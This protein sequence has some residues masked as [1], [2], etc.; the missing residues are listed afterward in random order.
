MK[1]KAKRWGNSLG[2]RLPKIYTEE[3]GI[4][5]DTELNLV[6][7]KGKLIITK[8]KKDTLEGM[9]ALVTQENIHAETSTGNVI[10][11]EIW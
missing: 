5:S 4:G 8:D 2:L 1:V 6:S 10:G 3:L 7:E 9:L 11:K